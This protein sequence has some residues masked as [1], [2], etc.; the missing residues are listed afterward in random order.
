M[1]AAKKNQETPPVREYSSKVARRLPE[2]IGV[3]RAIKALSNKARVR[4]EALV[5]ADGEEFP[6]YSIVLGSEKPNAPTLGVFGGVH[7]LERIGSDVVLAWISN[8]IELLEWDQT[9]I[10]RLKESRLVFVPLVNPAGM[11]LRRRSNVNHIDLMR[12]API[13][14][15]DKPI[16]LVGGHRISPRLPWYRGF[17]SKFE[18]MEI[19][20]QALCNV[21]MREIWPA[22]VSISVDVHSGFGSVDRLWF[23][24]AKTTEPPPHIAE[25]L[26][27]KK[28]FDQSYANHVYQ[29]E[30]QAKHYTTHGDLWDY[31]YDRHRNEVSNSLYIPW[32]LELGSWI[33]LKKNPRQFFSALGPFNPVQPH[34]IRRTLRR[35]ITLFDFLHRALISPKSWTDLNAK[36]REQY[37]Q[38]ARVIWYEEN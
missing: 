26:A 1:S 2:L 10:E 37:E 19:E 12:N 35:H 22:S 21:V 5:H 36:L 13:E 27:L 8:L 34:R 15:V 28:V 31:L 18:E 11:Y 29:L 6:I 23:P 17:A 30:P 25:I 3:E 38:N 24:Y 20:A 7:G 9:L 4:Q 33:W 16:A 14:A 32:C